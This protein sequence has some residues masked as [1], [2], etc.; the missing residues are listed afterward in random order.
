M[1]IAVDAMGGDYA[2]KEVVAG[3]EIARDRYPEVEFDLFGQNDK[4]KPLLNNAERIDLVQADEVIAMEDEPV[5][6]IRRKK[7][8]SIV[9][10]AQAVRDGADDAFFSAGNTGAILA[11][12]LLII[13]RIKGIDRPGLTTTL[14]VINNPKQDQ[15][16][17]LD[18]GANADSKPFNLYQYAILGKY[19][20]QTVMGFDNPRIGLLNNGTEADKGDMAHRAVH[21]ILGSAKDL[22][23]IG[24][25]ESR[26]LLNGA[27]DVVVTDGFTGNAVLKNTEGTAL[28]VLKLIKNSILE[29]S[30]TGKLGA[31]MLKP[32]FKNIQNKMDYSK[33]GGAVLLGVKA[34]VIKT[35]GSAKAE[36]IANTIGQIKSMLEN[37]SVDNVVSYFNDHS[38]EMAAMKADMQ[39]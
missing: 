2:P 20:A 34:P 25:V 31:A 21:D 12:G 28:S 27:A 5:R 14:P 33:Y 16:L 11:A 6:A 30:L 24:N 19:Y 8:S 18:V 32:T 13:G 15:F 23:F 36:T 1:K 39:K 3:I 29:G 9:L 26:E 35:H 22:N 17:M 37:H 4:V 10:A 38:D 7:Q